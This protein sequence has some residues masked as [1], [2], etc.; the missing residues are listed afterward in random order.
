MG[1]QSKHNGSNNSYSSSSHK[2]SQGGG[3]LGPFIYDTRSV[4]EMQYQCAPVSTDQRRQEMRY[5]LDT[6]DQQFNAQAGQA[7]YQQSYSG[8]PR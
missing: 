2:K 3:M 7:M 4:P 5:R 6:F 8:T 1:H